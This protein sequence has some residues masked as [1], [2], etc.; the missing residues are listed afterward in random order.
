[1]SV[2]FLPE[3]VRLWEILQAD[4]Q[5]K[6]APPLPAVPSPHVLFIQS[7][8]RIR[9]PPFH[10]YFMIQKLH[11]SVNVGNNGKL[12]LNHQLVHSKK[13][14]RPENRQYSTEERATG[15]RGDH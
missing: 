9:H 10:E 14:Y 6:T 3:A 1:M 12:P 4:G 2:C 11:V 7:S 15:H 13:V 8:C 5:L